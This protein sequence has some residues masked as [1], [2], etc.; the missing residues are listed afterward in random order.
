MFIVS[1]N[2]YYS[3]LVHLYLVIQLLILSNTSRHSVQTYDLREIVDMRD[4]RLA[5][6]AATQCNKTGLVAYDMMVENLL[7][8]SS[9]AIGSSGSIKSLRYNQQCENNEMV[10]G[11]ADHQPQI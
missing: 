1:I 6:C 3:L 7:T 10:L 4:I 11:M 2:K 5:L 8:V 9:L